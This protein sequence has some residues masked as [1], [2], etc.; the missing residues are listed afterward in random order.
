LLEKIAH[1]LSSLRLRARIFLKTQLYLRIKKNFTMNSKC[2]LKKKERYP[3][4]SE[5][6]ILEAQK[7]KEGNKS[8]LASWMRFFTAKTMENLK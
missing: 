1:R 5:I 6:H 2:F 8:P 4:S 7:I 3:G